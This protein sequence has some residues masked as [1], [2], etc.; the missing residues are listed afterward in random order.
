[1]LLKTRRDFTLCFFLFAPLGMAG[2][3]A[4][5]FNEGSGG[6]EGNIASQNIRNLTTESGSK[7]HASQNPE[8]GGEAAPIAAGGMSG[9]ERVSRLLLDGRKAY[10][11]GD[12]SAA[13]GQF[14]QA[15]E[16]DSSNSEARRYLGE[17]ERHSDGAQFTADA[18][19]G[20]L[21]V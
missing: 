2:Y 16:L 13:R 9:A 12:L 10:R 20:S 17:I 4:E 6:V 7:A 18:P 21:P 15:L 3:A 8:K 11:D 14:E 5:T 1:M 19:V